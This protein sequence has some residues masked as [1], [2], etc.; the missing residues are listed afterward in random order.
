MLNCD[1]YIGIIIGTSNIAYTSDIIGIDNSFHWTIFANID[2][3]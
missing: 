3:L 2:S 1:I